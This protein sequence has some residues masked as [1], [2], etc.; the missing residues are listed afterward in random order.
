MNNDINYIKTHLLKIIKEAGNIIL[1]NRSINIQY[2]NCEYK[3]IVTNIDYK[4]QNFLIDKLLTLI[5][6]ASVISEEKREKKEKNG[7][8]FIWIIDP[9]DGT[10][11]F[12]HHYPYFCISIALIKDDII[13]LGA[14]YNPISDELFYAIKNKGAFLN[15]QPIFVSKTSK[16]ENSLI[17]FGF[18]YDPKKTQSIIKI[19]NNIIHYVQD[20]RRTGS[21]ALDLAF[22]ACGRLDGFFEFDLEIWDYAA[23]SLLVSEAQGIVTNWNGALLSNRKSNI[24]ATNNKIYNNLLKNI[25]NT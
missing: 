1:K 25:T 18:P 23:G 9:I 13:I 19:T 8:K 3:N 16:L 6:E 4:V 20:L 24:I 21:A 22:I 5:P 15:D 2:K 11:N 12:T 14:I 10:T 17:G 7:K